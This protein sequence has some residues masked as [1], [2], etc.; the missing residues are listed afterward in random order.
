MAL[1][2]STQMG[3]FDALALAGGIDRST[4]KWVRL[5]AIHVR[6]RLRHDSKE[7][8]LAGAQGTQRARRRDQS[9]AVAAPD[10]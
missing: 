5:A 1:W 10:G 8:R 7:G 2:D 6:T 9:G 3:C 4:Q